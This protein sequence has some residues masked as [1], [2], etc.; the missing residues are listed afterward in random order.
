MPIVA[1]LDDVA[2]GLVVGTFPYLGF[3]AGPIMGELL[4]ALARG[5]EPRFD[6][7]P[8]SPARFG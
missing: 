2:P 4:A 5:L 3:S 6:L 1:A 7:S 8:Y